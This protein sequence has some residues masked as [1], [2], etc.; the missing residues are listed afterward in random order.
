MGY[1]KNIASYITKALTA[2]KANPGMQTKLITL[3][4]YKRDELEESF[5]VGVYVGARGRVGR[6]FWWMF[7]DRESLD[8]HKY[9]HLHTCMHALSLTHTH[10]HIRTHTHTA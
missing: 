4:A 7:H 6:V 2:E 9:R 5:T 8:T 10:P 3:N 1:N